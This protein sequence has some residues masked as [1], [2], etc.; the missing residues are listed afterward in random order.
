[1]PT[2]VTVEQI[3]EII[4]EFKMVISESQQCPW[5]TD[6]DTRQMHQEKLDALYRV[7]KSKE[8]WEAFEV[9]H[10]IAHYAL[11][12]MRSYLLH[13]LQNCE[14]LL[15][16]QYERVN[17]LEQ[18]VE[19]LESKN[20]R[21]QQAVYQS[22]PSSVTFPKEE[23]TI[24][25]AIQRAILHL[26]ASE[27][28]SRSWRIQ[29]RI[30]DIGLAQNRNSIRNALRKLKE[31]GLIHD[32]MWKGRI[33]G[34]TPIPGGQ[35]RLVT[36]TRERGR[37][38]CQKAFGEDPVECELDSMAR[39]HNSVSHAVG[40]L[41]ARDHLRA[42]DY[43]VDDDPEP[44]LRE[45]GNRWG[46][47]VEPDLTAVIDGTQWPIEVQREVREKHTLAKWGKTLGLAGRLAVI[48]FNEDKLKEQTALLERSRQDL[49][50]GEVRLASLRAMEL[51][52]WEWTL[53]SVT[54]W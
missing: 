21:L 24:R 33:V 1:M 30:I 31:T 34:W 51:G 4:R 2:E 32:Y 47:R 49:P 41:E 17:Q 14:K 36:L 37:V 53:L 18:Q 23:V 25:S 26:M 48:L 29:Q 3:D 43:P 44:I 50:E 12:E 52:D 45:Q 27:G 10:D 9:V 13:D 40:I 35:R 20:K 54:P 46:E 11:Q 8:L 39:R 28:L 15:K 6:Q 38:W 42:R 22:A 5:L 7:R 16:S 19:N